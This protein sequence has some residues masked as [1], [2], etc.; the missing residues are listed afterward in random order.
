[1]ASS[2]G[3]SPA[4]VYNRYLGTSGFKGVDFSSAPAFVSPDRFSDAKNVYKDYKSGL[5]ACVETFP[6]Y[7]LSARLFVGGISAT[8][9]NM[10]TWRVVQSINHGDET[11]AAGDYVALQAGK[12]LLIMA[13]DSMTVLAKAMNGKPYGTVMFFPTAENTTIELGSTGVRIMAVYHDTLRTCDFLSDEK[14]T[15]FCDNGDLYVLSSSGYFRIRPR[16]EAWGGENGDPKAWFEATT[17]TEPNRFDGTA[18][19]RNTYMPTAFI[20]GEK[21]EQMNALCDGYREMYTSVSVVD[22]EEEQNGRTIVKRTASFL[23]N[24]YAQLSYGYPDGYGTPSFYS[25][26]NVFINDQQIC[27]NNSDPFTNVFKV[28]YRGTEIVEPI[29]ESDGAFV[30][31]WKEEWPN[32]NRPFDEIRFEYE[33]LKD[34]EPSDNIRANDTLTIEVVGIPQ[35]VDFSFNGEFDGNPADAIVN[36]KVVA[37]H[38]GRLF[39]AG[40]PKIPN[41]VFYTQRT[42]NGI[43]DPTYFGAVNYLRVGGNGTGVKAAISVTSDLVVIKEASASHAEPSLYYI[44][45]TETGD[46]LVPKIYTVNPGAVGVGCTGEAINFVDDVVFASDHGIFG[47]NKLQTNLERS[48][49]CRSNFINGRFASEDPEVMMTVW[50][51]YLCVLCKSGHMYL[52]DSRQL[53]SAGYEWYY[54]D[55]IVAYKDDYDVYK[56]DT[57]VSGSVIDAS[58]EHV[59][60]IVHDYDGY[61]VSGITAGFIETSAGKVSVVYRKLKGS[62]PPK[63]VVLEYTGEREGGTPLLPISMLSVGKTIWFGTASGYLLVLN[64]DLRG[65]PNNE[66]DAGVDPMRIRSKWYTHMGHRY[67]SYVVTY[68]DDAGV[69]N[70]AKT[71]INR[72]TVIDMKTIPG[73]AFKVSVYTERDG[74]KPPAKSAA[75]ILDYGETDF[76]N[77]SYAN[78]IHTV[79]TLREHTHRWSRKMYRVYSDEFCR[80]FGIYRISYQYKVAGR[81]KD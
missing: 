2:Y 52:A 73:S 77:S 33:F 21:Y 3:F 14:A 61:P 10:I 40:N 28:F 55:S 72:S 78:D 11:I 34:S 29:Y 30:D 19:S 22:D 79:V 46:N 23:L 41:V 47:I 32:G 43:N 48:I 1:M 25:N 31:D 8:I 42:A 27:R 20:N 74:W 69:P 4:S 35:A 63:V 39:F 62:D 9:Y 75:G 37:Q 17:I 60:D 80:P 16:A 67:D 36:C 65:V 38:D 70:Q 44:R 68:Y 49:A 18:V 66:D 6:G 5:G 57:S 76:S 24:G 13:A 54:V 12:H 15:M 45:G 50:D 7:R 58:G 26:I 71:T 56:I 81:I 53:S 64:S 59:G 51:G